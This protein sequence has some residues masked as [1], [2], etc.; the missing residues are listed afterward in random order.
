VLEDVATHEVVALAVQLDQSH[1]VIPSIPS[2]PE[3][4]GECP[5]LPDGNGQIRGAMR[6]EHLAPDSSAPFEQIPAGFVR[7][8]PIE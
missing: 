8:S 7:I 4:L 2:I 5:G 1:F 3:G 6:D